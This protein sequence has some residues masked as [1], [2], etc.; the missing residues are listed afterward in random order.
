MN[1]LADEA[2]ALCDTQPISAIP[3]TPFPNGLPDVLEN[4]PH[5]FALTNGDGWEVS[6]F[7]YPFAAEAFI[8]GFRDGRHRRHMSDGIPETKMI[9]EY[10]KWIPVELARDYWRY[11]LKCGCTRIK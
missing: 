4:S 11:L 10:D 2:Q 3:H 5:R 8:V 1:T 6:F 9:V 7:H